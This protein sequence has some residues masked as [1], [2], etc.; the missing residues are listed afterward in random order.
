MKDIIL[1]ELE[2][3]EAQND[4]RIILAAE[5]G[6]RAWGFPSKDSDYDVRF[7]YVNRPDWYLSIAE[8]RGVIDLPVDDVLD[9]NGWDL[10]KALQLMRKSNS[11]LFEWLSSQI[12]YRLWP[13]AFERLQA[14]AR[15]AF[16]PETACHHYL[17]MAKSSISKYEG[18]NRVKLKT[19]MYAVRPVLC[20]QWIIRHLTHPP[21]R[22]EDLLVEVAE[23]RPFRDRMA[24][25][26]E[27]KKVH[28]EADTIPRDYLV[29]NYITERIGDI[30][31]RIPKNPSRPGL[32][33]FDEIFRSILSASF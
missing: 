20:C 15:I 27:Q 14:L 5:S 31:G 17:S 8:K 11:P 16:L 9:I 24:D 33:A 4:V 12:Q 22:I 7:I 3:I 30:Q 23:D 28:Y 18:G 21:M 29:E 19:Y 6:S 32:E 10:R 25:L 26:I 13:E 1:K 2:T